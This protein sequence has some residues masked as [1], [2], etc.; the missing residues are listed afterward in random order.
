[1]IV[2]TGDGGAH[3]DR[4]D[5]AEWSTYYIRSWLLGRKIL[6]L[7]EGVRRITR[8]PALLTRRHHAF[9][10]HA[11]RPRQ[12]AA[13]ARHARRGGALAGAPRGHRARHRERED[14]RRRRD[15]K[16]VV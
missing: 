3:A 10:P 1:M 8:L 4:D 12:E 11:H 9:R 2:G 14:D 5:G 13:R 16:S 7:E 15:R 6:P